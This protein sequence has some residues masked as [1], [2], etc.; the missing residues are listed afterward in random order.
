MMNRSLSSPTAA[1]APPQNGRAQPLARR[2]P[3]LF[4]ASDDH[5]M[6]KKIQDTH[7]PDGRDVD[8]NVILQVIQEIFQQANYPGVVESTNNMATSIAKLE[9]KATMAVDGILE[10][11]SFITHKVSCELQ[12][13]CS[14][15]GDTNA[16][17]MAIL[18]MLS[19][20]QWDAK[21]VLTLAAFA[22][23]YGE[24]WLVA[25]LFAT[26]PL[27]KSVAILK[28][29]PD[30]V[31]HA[32]P[33]KSCFDAVNNVIRAVVEVT[34]RIM[35]F[36]RLPANYI[37][38][39][40]PPLSVAI[41]H[42]PTAVYWTIKSIVACSAQLTSLLGINYESLL[43]TTME[44][45]EITSTTHKLVHISDHLKEQLQI[46]NQHIEEKMHIEYYRMVVHLFEISH[47][48]NMKI[49]KA[50]IYNKDDILP[51]EVGTTHTRAS[52]EVLRRK[53]VLLLLSD[54]D[55]SDEE[56]SV[57]SN[58]YEESRTKPELQYEIVWL[59]ILERPTT[60]TMGWNTEMDAKFKERQAMMPWYTLHHPSLLEPA[61]LKF[62]KEKWHFTK[63]MMLVA[64]DPHQGKVASLNALHM[65]WIWGNLAYPFTIAKEESLW[66]MEP[67]WNIELIVDGID[68][69]IIEWSEQGKYICL[70]GGENIEWIKSFTS[71]V[72]SVAERAGIE[73][74]M[75]Y[76]G[77]SN[78]RER[79]R[80]I[81]DTIT[82]E[83]LSHCWNDWN[84]VWYFWARINSM[85]YSK[86]LLGRKHRDDKVMDEVLNLLGF[87]G[88]E[89]G[90]AI[91]SRG[92]F[93]MARAKSDVLLNT[94]GNFEE[95]EGDARVQG[96]VPALIAYFLKLRTPHHCNRVI[97]P[98]IGGDVPEVIVCSEC[99][100]QM[101]K[102][103]MYRC[104]A[105]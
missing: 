59:P 64:L 96:F 21:V 53:T 75:V 67:S 81:N 90:W 82:K 45:W 76:V 69:N 16:A 19:N 65:V 56:L 10:G 48:D 100:R 52:I 4:S 58:I 74:H 28:Q 33:L 72:K 85:L 73:L 12:C 43:A 36:K 77:K 87:D 17:T 46:C 40:Q 70:Y 97:L 5:N 44:T 41:T 23:A 98:G 88:S 22:I 105:D 103:F 83:G 80:K 47:F 3:Q 71:L 27:A 24:F 94:L 95:W 54:L 14:G 101:E 89:E 42:I 34:R 15:G 99:G 68:Q 92:S 63:K 30:I 55:I 7:T 91:I 37:S 61:V 50:L 29:V 38:D 2:T 25:Q 26:N 20:Y 51:L 8:A 66:S 1:L 60:A 6:V 62:V 13:R 39:D 57:L 31:E 104:C 11:L 18:N 84:L 93:E 86:L 35:E 9:E 32:L 79:V 78:N 102:F 49:I